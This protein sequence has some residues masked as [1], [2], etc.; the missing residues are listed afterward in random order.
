MNESGHSKQVLGRGMARCVGSLPVEAITDL[1]YGRYLV[2]TASTSICVLDIGPQS[3]SLVRFPE[4]GSANDWEG[5]PLRG[6]NETVPL[7]GIVH[8]QLGARAVFRIDVRGDGVETT[9]TT[10]PVCA[11][12]RL[13]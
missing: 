8:L 11:I 4:Y 5:V 7:L 3:S 10:T 13:A 1:D 12:R 2:V 9:R 6:D